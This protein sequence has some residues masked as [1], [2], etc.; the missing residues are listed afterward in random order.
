MIDLIKAVFDWQFIA[1][2]F[3]FALI[4]SI[5]NINLFRSGWSW[6]P[7]TKINKSDIFEEKIHQNSFHL[8]KG[9]QTVLALWLI[10]IL[11]APSVVIS[12]LNSLDFNVDVAIM[13][14]LIM[15][16][17]A[18]VFIW[19]VY[20]GLGMFTW[21][22]HIILIKPSYWKQEIWKVFPFVIYTKWSK[23]A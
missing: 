9:T 19:L 8:F 15:I 16:L 10:W 4:E 12:V 11:R 7:F 14:L 1:I 5:W 3:V 22:Y 2:M 23:K 21:L 18:P 17:L 13:D 6:L 20:Y